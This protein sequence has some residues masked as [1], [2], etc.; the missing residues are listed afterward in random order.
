MDR[1]ILSLHLLRS[2]SVAYCSTA[3]PKSLSDV[4]VGT[5]WRENAS[6]IVHYQSRRETVSE[7]WDTTSQLSKAFPVQRLNTYSLNMA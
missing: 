7:L 2:V 6:L 3:I 4:I 5:W 1:E